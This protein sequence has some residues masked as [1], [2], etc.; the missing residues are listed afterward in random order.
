MF[1]FDYKIRL[2]CPD[3]YSAKTRLKKQ[4]DKY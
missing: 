2:K 4:D 3:F 1:F